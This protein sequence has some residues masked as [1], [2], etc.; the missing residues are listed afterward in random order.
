MRRKKRE[1]E[2]LEKLR[3]SYTD[4]MDIND[5]DDTDDDSPV[6]IV[7]SEETRDTFQGI[8]SLDICMTTNL[9]SI[10]FNQSGVIRKTS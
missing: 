4:M 10:P 3:S 1:R 7:N 9:C 6:D 8:N 5:H 2:S